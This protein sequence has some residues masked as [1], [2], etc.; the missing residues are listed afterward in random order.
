M[1]DEERDPVVVVVEGVADDLC[2]ELSEMIE[3]DYPGGYITQL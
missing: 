2:M 1:V 3:V